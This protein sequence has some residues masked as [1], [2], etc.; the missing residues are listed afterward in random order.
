MS[1]QLIY[2]YQPL[3]PS[4]HL[5]RCP[6]PSTPVSEA[7]VLNPPVSYFYHSIIR[8]PNVTAPDIPGSATSGAHNLFGLF[9]SYG[10]YSVVFTYF[11]SLETCSSEDERQFAQTSLLQHS[12]IEVSF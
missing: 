2:R 1:Q 11:F 7:E 12:R 10:P 8:P 5:Y 9:H 6:P 3:P 4:P